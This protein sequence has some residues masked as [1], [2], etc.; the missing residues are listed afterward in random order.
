[1]LKVKGLFPLLFISISA[2]LFTWTLLVPLVS[3]D[4]ISRALL[5][6]TKLLSLRFPRE[7]PAGDLITSEALSINFYLSSLILIIF[8]ALSFG[9]FLSLFLFSI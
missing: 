1:M 8:L 3:L 5:L 9:I 2:L 4:T 7:G 6:L